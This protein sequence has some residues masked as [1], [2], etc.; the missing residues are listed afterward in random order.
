MNKSHFFH[1]INPSNLTEIKKEEN[2]C[3]VPKEDIRF[4]SKRIVMLTNKLLNGGFSQNENIDYSF[5]VYLSQCIEYFKFIDKQELIQNKICVESKTQP[6]NIKQSFSNNN[7]SND[8]SNNMKDINN[9]I[10][11]NLEKKQVKTITMNKFIKTNKVQKK[12]K[13]TFPKIQTYNLKKSNFKEKG[14]HKKKSN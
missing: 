10:T 6:L 12:Q 4:Y 8:G 5:Q 7:D 2:G 1:I 9:I 11:N 3:E 14:L 13:Q